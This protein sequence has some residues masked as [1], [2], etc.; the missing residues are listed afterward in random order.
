MEKAWITNTGRPSPGDANAYKVSESGEKVDT[1]AQGR[2]GC[3]EHQLQ[4]R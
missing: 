1:E 3:R 4:V 2:H